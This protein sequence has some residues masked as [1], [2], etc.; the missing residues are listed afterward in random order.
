MRRLAHSAESKKLVVKVFRYCSPRYV[1]STR[2]VIRNP[3]GSSWYTLFETD[4]KDFLIAR[5]VVASS[6]GIQ[7][8]FSLVNFFWSEFQ[9]QLNGSFFDFF[10]VTETTARHSRTTVRWASSAQKEFVIFTNRR[11]ALLAW[12][13]LTI[14]LSGRAEL[15]LQ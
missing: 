2:G 15:L 6:V 9:L 8:F 4:C 5:R 10:N 7:L 14:S 12:D 1:A 3:H 11:V 13:T